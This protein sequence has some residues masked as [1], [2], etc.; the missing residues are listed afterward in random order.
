MQK[1]PGFW[2]TH[3]REGW[4]KLKYIIAR[5]SVPIAAAGV[6]INGTNFC[7]TIIT[8]DDILQQK[9]DQ[10][11]W[12]EGVQLMEYILEALGDAESGWQGWVSHEEYAQ[13]KVKLEIVKEQFLDYMA[14]NQADGEAWCRVWPFPRSRM[15]ITKHIE[16]GKLNRLKEETG[17]GCTTSRKKANGYDMRLHLDHDQR[18]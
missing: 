4:G 14:Q 13:M 17:N 5:N 10:Q 9:A 1:V 6:Q 12:K 8:D 18:W 2:Q 3:A 11:K 16:H 7:P 15:K